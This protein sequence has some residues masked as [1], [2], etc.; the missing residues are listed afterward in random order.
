MTDTMSTE[1]VKQKIQWE[2]GLRDT[3]EYGLDGTKFED[4]ALAAAWEAARAC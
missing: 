3:L 4:P 1:R 2:G